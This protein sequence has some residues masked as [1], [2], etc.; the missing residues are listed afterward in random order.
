MLDVVTCGAFDYAIDS[1]YQPPGTAEARVQ[2]LRALMPR[3]WSDRDLYAR[4]DFSTYGGWIEAFTGFHDVGKFW[5]GIAEDSPAW[6]V[7]LHALSLLDTYTWMIPDELHGC[8]GIRA[9]IDA[10]LGGDKSTW[11][12]LV[13]SWTF[14]EVNACGFGSRCTPDDSED[15]PFGT[16]YAWDFTRNGV[17]DP[18]F[19]SIH[20]CNLYVECVGT[21]TD[22]ALFEAHRLYW[23]YREGAQYNGEGWDE[24]PEDEQIP[25]RM[26][27]ATMY[28]GNATLACRFGMSF[29]L[30]LATDIL[31]ELYHVVH[32]WDHVPYHCGGACCGW[33]VPARWGLKVAA[34][35]GMVDRG[36]RNFDGRWSDQ[37][38]CDLLEQES[39]GASMSTW[40]FEAR[41]LTPGVEDGSWR[42]E[43]DKVPEECQ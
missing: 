36:D 22:L 39:S 4:H 17:T 31:H 41:L 16:G 37:R 8:A 9:S 29:V 27:A 30:S 25:A 15:C 21:A 23:A 7:V 33:R 35:T 34:R 11:S 14:F 13:D 24:L 2:T 5:T 12:L 43:Q 32:A 42:V 28:V 26:A 18:I 38:I 10:L 1:T 19:N 20:L 40:E 3:Y 6:H